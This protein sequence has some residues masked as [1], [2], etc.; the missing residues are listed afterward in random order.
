MTGQL[1]KDNSRKQAY[2][3]FRKGLIILGVPILIAVVI[4]LSGCSP[5]LVNM[6]MWGIKLQIEKGECPFN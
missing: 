1:D 6:E 4:K 5:V 3:P 2:F